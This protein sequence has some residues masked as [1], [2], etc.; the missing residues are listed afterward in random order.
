MKRA[1][2]CGISGQDGAYLA[3]LLLQKGY[4]VWG[5]SR[6]AQSY[7]MANL[8]ALSIRQ[9]VNLLSMAPNDF[10]SVLTA[11]EQSDPDEIYYL[12]GQSSVGLSCARSKTENGSTGRA[13]IAFRLLHQR[14]IPANSLGKEP[15][16]NEP[17][18]PTGAN[19][20]TALLSDRTATSICYSARHFPAGKG[21]RHR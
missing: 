4:E 17:N 19:S 8:D 13:P 6:D 16:R 20:P 10:R 1:L 2:I 5:T 7:L 18:D 9:Q 15:S 14:P 11:V 21:A 12:T 3:E